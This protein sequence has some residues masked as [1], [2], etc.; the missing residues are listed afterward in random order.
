VGLLGNCHSRVLCGRLPDSGKHLGWFARYG[1]ELLRTC[2]ELSRRLDGERVLLEGGHSHLLLESF[3]F[4]LLLLENQ[5]PE[6]LF[7]LF[8]L[9]PKCLLVRRLVFFTC[10]EFFLEGGQVFKS[11]VLLLS[12]GLFQLL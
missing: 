1:G 3:P 7:L 2:R 8:K 12:L 11:V 5:L 10:L 9:S 6:L 4:C